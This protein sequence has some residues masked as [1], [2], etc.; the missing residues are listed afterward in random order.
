MKFSTL[1]SVAFLALTT[2]ALAAPAPQPILT[3]RQN[4][5]PP[6]SNPNQNASLQ[7]FVSSTTCSGPPSDVIIPVSYATTLSPSDTTLSQGCYEF[8]ANGVSTPVQSVRITGVWPEVNK[9]LLRYYEGTGCAG[10]GS[11]FG[12]VAANTCG[13]F[14]GRGIGSYQVVC[15]RT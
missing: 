9:C 10:G 2:G 6:L 7:P 8:V 13:G 14:G 15:E 12:T 1:P 5:Q 3:N 11:A 4:S